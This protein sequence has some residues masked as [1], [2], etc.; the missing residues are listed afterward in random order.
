[1]K[2]SFRVGRRSIEVR[3]TLADRVVGYFSPTAHLD[4]MR[5][6]VSMEAATGIGG[7]Y[8]GGKRD[9]RQ[10]RNWRPAEGSANADTIPDLPDLRARARDLARNMP[11]AGG[12]IATVV[13]NVVGEGLM[14]APSIDHKLL[15]LT[16]E[17]KEAWET[18]AAMEFSLAAEGADFTKVLS[19]DEMQALALRSVMESGDVFALRRYRE[20]P[21]EV[22]GTRMQMIEADRVSNPGR[23]ADTASVVGGIR[24]NDDGVAVGYHVSNR[25]PG[26]YLLTAGAT[27]AW[28]EV[29]ARDA[30]GRPLVLHLAE[31]LRPDQARGV[32]YLAP[33]IEL[34]RVLGGY[35]ENEATAALV[36][37]MFTV[38]VTSAQDEGGA[39]KPIVGETDSTTAAN[40]LKLGPGA[41]I[42]LADGED[43]KMA[44]PL[45]PNAGFDAFVMSLCRQ[46]GVALELPY[47]LLIKH[48][49]ASYSASRA[50]LE[51]AWQ[52]FRKRR[53]WLARRFCQ[54]YYEMVLWEA[55]ARG[56]L[57]A[58]GFFD[59]PLIRRAW[60]GAY[61][62]GPARIS[63]NQYVDAQA[64]DLNLQNRLISRERIIQERFG[65]TFED[66]RSQLAKEERVLEAAGLKAEA[67]QPAP[68]PAPGSEPASDD[69]GND[70]EEEDE[71]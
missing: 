6:R 7:G 46:I 16:E 29:P 2:R 3:E 32:P 25:H 68:P 35:T 15:G 66:T 71:A 62:N 33:V 24:F 56:R 12:A 30:D 28:K 37:S 61:W 40:E 69:Q 34:L 65:G 52:F 9:R 53:A 31:R 44:N 67:P 48:F 49:T 51:T 63:L 18:A 70:T 26:D 57:E 4:R 8:T 39:V 11:I 59:D 23:A 14:V 10:T 41:I 36:T 1:M 13:T 47:E 55:V 58:P 20:D 60:C 54:P 5:A 17:Q 21:G 42:D 19:F 43:V 38:F 50:A 45:R 27:L 64:D 22:Y